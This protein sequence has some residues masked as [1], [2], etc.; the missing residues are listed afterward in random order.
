MEQLV[1]LLD[2]VDAAKAVDGARAHLHVV[3]LEE[4]S[5]HVFA[6]FLHFAH[7]LPQQGLDLCFRLR[8]RGEI[9]PRG[10]DMLRLRGEYLHLVAT[11]KAVA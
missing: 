4:G 1:G 7:L 11:L 2:V 3:L 5:Q 9:H 6:A 8:R 10:V